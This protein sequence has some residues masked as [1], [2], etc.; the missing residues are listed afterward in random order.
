[1]GKLLTRQSSGIEVAIGPRSS[2]V[3]PKKA[4]VAF[5]TL[6]SELATC[7]AASGFLVAESNTLLT[8]LAPEAEDVIWGNIY[9]SRWSRNI[10]ASVAYCCY[11]VLGLFWGALVS[12]FSTAAVASG[13]FLLKAGVKPSSL[14]FAVVTRYLP[15]TLQLGVLALLPVCVQF[16]GSNWEGIISNSELQGVVFSRYFLFQLVNIIVTIGSISAFV[17]WRE[18]GLNDV[19]TLI[20]NTFPRVGAYFVEQ[21]GNTS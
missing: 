8:R 2:V 19:P 1:V 11:L 4:E 9:I 5:A 6:T 20:V 21:V 10:R 17:F 3:R 13:D 12:L 16:T 15:V 18:Y 14:F 7:A